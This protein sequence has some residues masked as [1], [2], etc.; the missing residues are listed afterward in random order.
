MAFLMV[1]S[2]LSWH[3]HLP[4]LPS[5]TY[6]ANLPQ[7]R[8]AV[9]LMKAKRRNDSWK[10]MDEDLERARATAPRAWQGSKIVSDVIE[11][12]KR[13]IAECEEKTEA[14]IATVEE[15]NAVTEGDIP[16]YVMQNSWK[17]I[18]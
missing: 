5:P 15:E 3:P 8:S 11:K 16:A 12:A 6:H 10:K 14:R 7:P 1:A 2:T 4:F 9:P 13:G 18:L 17:Q